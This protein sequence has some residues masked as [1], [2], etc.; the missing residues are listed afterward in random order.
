[1]TARPHPLQAALDRAT[2]ATYTVADLI[3]IARARKPST[4]PREGRTDARQVS[5]YR[6]VIASSVGAIEETFEA[7]TVAGLSSLGTPP[8]ALS[9]LAMAIAKS[10]QSPNPQNLDNLLGDYLGFTP[11]DYWDAHLAY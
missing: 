11:S 9:R 5:L 4:G 3:D 10:M 8:L 2:S 6:A 7:M 1:M